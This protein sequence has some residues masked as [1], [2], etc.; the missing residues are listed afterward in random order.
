M[1]VILLVLPFSSAQDRRFFG[2]QGDLTITASP[3]VRHILVGK[4][5]LPSLELLAFG[6]HIPVTL[7]IL[8]KADGKCKSTLV[9]LHR[10][11]YPTTGPSA[12][13]LETPFRKEQIGFPGIV[14]CLQL[15]GELSLSQS[16]LLLNTNLHFEQ[17]VTY[18]SS[19]PAF[20]RLGPPSQSCVSDSAAL[21]WRS[22]CLTW[23]VGLCQAPSLSPPIFPKKHPNLEA[24]ENEA[25]NR[26]RSRIRRGKSPNALTRV[27][28]ESSCLDPI[29]DNALPAPNHYIKSQA[30]P[31]HCSMVDMPQLPLPSRCPSWPEASGVSVPYLRQL[32]PLQLEASKPTIPQRSR[33]PYRPEASESQLPYL[34]QL[35]LLR[36]EANKSTISQR[37]SRQFWL[38]ASESQIRCLRRD[39]HLPRR[40]GATEALSQ[41][42]QPCTGRLETSRFQPFRSC[43]AVPP[44]TSE[45][46]VA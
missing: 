20:P 16:L 25:T 33:S 21:T 35:Y 30:S 44:P 26:P 27:T 8:L 42:R 23:F 28:P 22:I 6:G 13:H 40:L 7:W 36:S 38:R 29:W 24:P 11:D 31:F 4:P 1:H 14:K 17:R 34:H 12:Y 43:L 9:Q 45:D 3:V 39:C 32:R 37:L 46:F 19:F 18:S 5:V 15:R 2:H 41:I 10:P